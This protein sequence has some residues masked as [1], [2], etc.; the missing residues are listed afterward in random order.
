MP[1]AEPWPSAPVYIIQIDDGGNERE[2]GNVL[3]PRLVLHLIE[4]I[5]HD[6]APIKINLNISGNDESPITRD[7]MRALHAQDGA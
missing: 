4:F 6:C 1:S 3:G 7:Y 2:K 5:S